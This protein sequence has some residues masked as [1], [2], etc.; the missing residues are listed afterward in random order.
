MTNCLL[1]QD[2]D[3]QNKYES[4]WNA[5]IIEPKKTP[6]LENMDLEQYQVNN[7][8]FKCSFSSVVEKFSSQFSISFFGLY[9]C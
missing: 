8:S 4:K 2:L 6:D 9:A 1:E 5:Q 3:D 7:F